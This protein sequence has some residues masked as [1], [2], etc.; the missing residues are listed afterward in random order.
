MK[1]DYHIVKEISWKY[2]LS[3]RNRVALSGQRTVRVSVNI[4]RIYC[5]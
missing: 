4:I 1:K 3:V 5:T 2:R